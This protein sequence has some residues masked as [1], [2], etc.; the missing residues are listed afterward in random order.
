MDALEKTH[1]VLS[2]LASGD[3]APPDGHRAQQQQMWWGR[4]FR[5]ERQDVKMLNKAK[6]RNSFVSLF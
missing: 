4:H 1:V 3:L 5:F 2:F 6:I